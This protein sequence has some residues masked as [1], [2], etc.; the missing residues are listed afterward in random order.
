MTGWQKGILYAAMALAV[1]LIISIIGGIFGVLGLVNI[2]GDSA[3]LGETKSY[4]LSADAEELDLTIKAAKLNIK[5]GSTFALE[6]NLKNLT[7][8][9]N[10]NCLEIKEKSRGVFAGSHDAVLT[11]T[12][13]QNHL[14]NVVKLSTG[15]GVVSIN[16]ISANDLS[17]GL[18]AGKADFSDIKVTAEAEIEG[19]T[20]K[21]TM[22]NCS[23][24]NF[25][26]DMGVGEVVFSGE[27]TG[28]SDLECG[29]GALTATLTGNKED[30]TILVDKGIGEIV[31]DGVSMADDQKTGSGVNRLKISGGIGSV[32]IKFKGSF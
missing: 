9:E 27:I 24:H 28:N 31:V 8:N 30:Y 20:G 4:S 26:L 22:Q 12:I 3:V 17:V 16:G 5:T 15:A 29:V 25:D 18:G 14:F 32:K 23:F 2:F 19:G 6:S 21:L 11:L 13:P 10:N 1:A 7:V